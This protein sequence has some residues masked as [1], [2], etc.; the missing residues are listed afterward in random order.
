MIELKG[1]A[2]AYKLQPCRVKGTNVVNIRKRPSD[3]F[4]SMGWDEFERALRERGLAVYKAEE[5]DFL[6]IMKDRQRL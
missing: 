3:K 4:E 6:K 5:S 2:S 1:L